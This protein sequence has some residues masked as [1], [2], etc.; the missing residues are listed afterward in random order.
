MIRANHHAFTYTYG[1]PA[2]DR[3]PPSRRPGALP[4]RARTPRLLP[5]GP[6]D[7]ADLPTPRPRRHGATVSALRPPPFS[8]LG[9]RAGLRDEE[10]PPQLGSPAD[11]RRTGARTRGRFD[12]LA[13]DPDASA[14]FPGRLAPATQAAQ[15]TADA[16]F[17]SGHPRPRGLGGRRRRESQDAQRPS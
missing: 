8:Q 14:R 1:N 10:A 13:R 2:G 3:S 9:R 17:G 6:A 12:R 16:S 15:E 11:P 5:H 7:L 4:N